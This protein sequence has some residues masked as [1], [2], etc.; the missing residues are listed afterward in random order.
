MLACIAHG[1]SLEVPFLAVLFPQIASSNA[2]RVSS[3]P[4]NLPVRHPATC[5]G[6]TTCVPKI[7]P[8]AS[9][10]RASAASPPTKPPHPVLSTRTH[11]THHPAVDHHRENQI[12]GARPFRPSPE[13]VR[14]RVLHWMCAH[15]AHL[16]VTVADIERRP[17]NHPCARAPPAAIT[18]SRRPL[19]AALVQHGSDVARS[20]E[21]SLFARH[22]IR[23]FL[24]RWVVARMALVRLRASPQEGRLTCRTRRIS[25]PVARGICQQREPHANS[26]CTTV[27]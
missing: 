17:P 9:A 5:F 6:V 1:L 16:L 13:R 18:I 14:G 7:S 15:D 2:A 20:P 22:A 8:S 24:S 23:E 4:A 21:T 3:K 19:W 10:Y 12:A 11:P 25:H 26:H 27:T